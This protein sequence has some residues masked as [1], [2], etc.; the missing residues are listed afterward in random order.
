MVVPAQVVLYRD[1]EVLSALGDVKPMTMDGVV[2][3]YGFPL[4]C[5]ADYLALGWIK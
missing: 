5:D 4:P 2:G 3:L 1:P